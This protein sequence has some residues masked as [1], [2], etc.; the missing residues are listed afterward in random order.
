MFFE[1]IKNVDEM[2]CSYILYS[3]KLIL[4]CSFYARNYVALKRAV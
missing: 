3:F 4:N 1:R 2:F